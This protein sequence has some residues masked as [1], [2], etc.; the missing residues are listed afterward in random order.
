MAYSDA[1]MRQHEK[2]C[3][4]VGSIVFAL[5]EAGHDSRRENIV[6]VLRSEIAETG[7][8]APDQVIYLQR[9]STCWNRRACCR[10]R[11]TDNVRGRH[12][13]VTNS[14]NTAVH[15]TQRQR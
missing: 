13:N 5:A 3:Q 4:V 15:L 9:P 11:E 2:M 12:Q 6:T 8:R 14:R 1:F 7:K 10:G